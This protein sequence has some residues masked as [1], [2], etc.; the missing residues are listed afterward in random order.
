[1]I[2]ELDE[3]PRGEP[4]AW[5]AGALRLAGVW[6]ETKL[7]ELTCPLKARSPKQKLGALRAAAEEADRWAIATSPAE[8]AMRRG[9]IGIEA[10][11]RSG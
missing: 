9:D 2:L 8:V 5:E 10:Q 11:Q 6:L 1:M 7:W 3:S 4:I